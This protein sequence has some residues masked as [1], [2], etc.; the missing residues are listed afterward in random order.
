MIGE[1]LKCLVCGSP[2]WIATFPGTEAE[3]AVQGN[4]CILHPAPEVP[5]TAWC[6]D[7]WPFAKVM[8]AAASE[9]RAAR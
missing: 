7:H 3:P 6:A 8:N 4:L 2:D 1:T 9:R 5:M